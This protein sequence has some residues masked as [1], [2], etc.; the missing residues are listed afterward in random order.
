MFD[1]VTI[2]VKPEAVWNGFK[3]AQPNS[4]SV[5]QG[6][7]KKVTVTVPGYTDDI[8]GGQAEYP[9]LRT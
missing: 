9:I 2:T 4:T 8:F 6:F 5:Q 3:R 1:V 7:F